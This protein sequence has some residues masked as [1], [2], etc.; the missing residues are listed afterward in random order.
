MHRLTNSQ[1]FDMFAMQD[2]LNCVVDPH[3]LTANYPWTRAIRVECAELSDH[4][5]WKWWKK[6]TPSWT[7]A[8]IE[9]VDIWHFM[10]SSTLVSVRGSVMLAVAELNTGL[11]FPHDEPMELLGKKFTLGSLKMH[12]QIDMLSAFASAGYCFPALFESIMV[13][14]GL[15]W[16]ALRRLYLGKNVLNRFRQAN[17][18]ADGTYEKLWNGVEDNVRLEQ[19][20]ELDPTLTADQLHAALWHV[21]ELVPKATNQIPLPLPF[22]EAA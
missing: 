4:I 11:R 15:T 8:H 14:T 7:Q 10:L 12:E 16:E 1:L 3:W 6:Q 18:Y 21:Y 20:M 19:I 17:G 2:S 22:K 5:G 13:S 9:L